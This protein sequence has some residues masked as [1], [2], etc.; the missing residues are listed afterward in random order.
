MNSENLPFKAF[1]TLIPLWNSVNKQWDFEMILTQNVWI[2][3]ISNN[4][5]E[6]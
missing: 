1:K 3:I 4:Y 6:V 2:N 5:K